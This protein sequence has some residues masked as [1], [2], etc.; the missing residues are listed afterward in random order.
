MSFPATRPVVARV[1]VDGR[2]K[3]GQDAV[4][5]PFVRGPTA[6]AIRGRIRL[7]KNRNECYI[8]LVADSSPRFGAASG[9]RD[10]KGALGF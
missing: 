4:A 9:E 5:E 2:D 8:L 1:G 6:N 7:T 3:R 10:Q